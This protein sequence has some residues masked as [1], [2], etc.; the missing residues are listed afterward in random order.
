MALINSCCHALWRVS[1]ANGKPHQP[2]R[3]NNKTHT[4]TP[5]ELERALSKHEIIGV[6]QAAQHAARGAKGA[7]AAAEARAKRELGDLQ[8][9]L[10]DKERGAA[11]LEA[12]VGDL[13]GRAAALAA[14]RDGAAA[15]CARL[16]GECEELRRRAAAAAL[17][18]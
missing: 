13:S 10:R 9:M 8:R 14:A 3:R 7:A 17:E 5:Q 18:R 15:G 2:G 11:A 16:Q 4:Q 6:K 12:R 1:V